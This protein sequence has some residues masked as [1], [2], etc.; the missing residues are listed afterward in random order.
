MGREEK[1]RRDKE[2]LF[3][4]KAIEKCFHAMFPSETNITS[5][6]LLILIGNNNT[7]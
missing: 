1:R 5:Q 6:N 2:D 4:N 7:I 3:L